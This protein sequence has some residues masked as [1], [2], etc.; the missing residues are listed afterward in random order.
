MSSLRTAADVFAGPSR[1][2]AE[3][4]AARSVAFPLVAATVVSILVNVIAVP[5][6]DLR[7]PVA[8]ALDRRPPE[9]TA[10]MTSHQREEAIAQGARIGRLLGYAGGV[11]LPAVMAVAVAFFL[12]V[13][14]RVGGAR[15]PFVPTLAVASWALLPLYVKTI[16][17]VPAIL[18]QEALDPRA[19]D[20]LLPT[21][22][23]AFFPDGA[24]G[25]HVRLLSALDLF[26]LWSLALV[27]L[28]MAPL[29]GVSK[30]RA[31]AV[32]LVLWLA[33]VAISKVALGAMAS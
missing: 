31:A 27:I 9:A 3:A 2:L 22:P 8:E 11:V 1:G 13:G 26:A 21:S 33:W 29:A 10:E 6:H 16:L 20:R 14:F 32:V 23:A 4:A 25:V 7:K 18:R 12:F 15:P 17:A 19:L 28:G 30:A 24:T 5:H